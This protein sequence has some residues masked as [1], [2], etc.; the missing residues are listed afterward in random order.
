MHRPLETW[1]SLTTLEV[2]IKGLQSTSDYRYYKCRLS[3][4]GGTR[5]K[6]VELAVRMRK[7]L[8]PFVFKCSLSFFFSSL[9]MP[10]RK[11]EVKPPIGPHPLC[12]Q[13]GWGVSSQPLSASP[14]AGRSCRS[15]RPRLSP[16][17]PWYCL[18]RFTLCRQPS[19]ML[20]TPRWLLRSNASKGQ[21]AELIDVWLTNKIE[22]DPARC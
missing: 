10:V 18:P 17:R 19:T 13:P 1:L 22:I 14:R 3:V 8:W 9:K 20:S 15:T 6:A 21:Q 5:K 2:S 7:T 4:G 12:W 11:Q 16:S